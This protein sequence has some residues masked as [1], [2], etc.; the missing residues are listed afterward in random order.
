MSAPSFFVQQPR[1][2][3]LSMF[4]FL[5]SVSSGFRRDA[6]ALGL[7]VDARFYVPDADV[8]VDMQG[9][10]WKRQVAIPTCAA[11]CASQADAK[12]GCGPGLDLG[13]A[14][15][16]PTF[17]PDTVNCMDV[18]CTTTD[19][20]QGQQVLQSACLAVGTS[21]TSAATSTSFSHSSIS[22]ASGPPPICTTVSPTPS[23]GTTT[24]SV[25]VTATI[26]ESASGSSAPASASASLS[27][28]GTS[29][30]PVTVVTTT[31]RITSN[32]LPAS[33]SATSP[34]TVVTSTST[35]GGVPTAAGGAGAGG[36]NGAVGDF[37]GI[38]GALLAA[39]G[40]VGV[41]MML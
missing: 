5:W 20:Q 12:V 18:N 9:E 41:L 15:H 17:L 22:I 33:S 29:S 24:I 6:R 16:S 7:G 40:G 3:V 38:L 13:C 28:T 31:T 4:L 25:T 26:T 8:M 27:D 35:L 11:L 1:W 36:Q 37:R 34:V 19:K 14:C 10:M 23:S 30:V 21:T 32:S 2:V 39:L